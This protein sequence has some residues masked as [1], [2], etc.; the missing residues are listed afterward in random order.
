LL[1][2]PRKVPN[3]LYLGLTQGSLTEKG[4]KF[5]LFI[6]QIED[7]F[8]QSVLLIIYWTLAKSTSKKLWNSL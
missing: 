5:S 2:L 7:F 4:L 1:Y 6:L 8:F 3:A